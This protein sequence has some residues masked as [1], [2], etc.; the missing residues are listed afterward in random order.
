MQNKPLQA[1]IKETI[2]GVP[3][4]TEPMAVEIY[5][6]DSKMYMKAPGQQWMIMEVP[7]MA[8]MI[9][10]QQDLQSDPVKAMALLQQMG[11]KL[12]FGNDQVIEGTPY[13]AIDCKV[14]MNKFQG[15]LQNIMEQMGMPAGPGT[16]PEDLK[17]VLEKLNMDYKYTFYVNKATFISDLM[18]IDL[19]MAMDLNAADLAGGTTPS[20]DAPKSVK[21]NM[22]MTGQIRLTDIGQ[23]FQAPDVS[24]ATP[25]Q[26]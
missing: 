9:S 19:T 12:T 18:S 14:D 4:Q 23:P 8:E 17:K 1:Y 22:A 26:Q 24:G 20:A 6:N 21:M 5:M 16:S 2:G 11:M 25:M 13:Y 7:G 3:G 10:Q 15:N